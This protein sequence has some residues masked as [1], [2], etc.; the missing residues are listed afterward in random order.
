MTATAGDSMSLCV[1]ANAT[2]QGS[3]ATSAGSTMHAGATGTGRGGAGSFTALSL[4]GS[5]PRS[6]SP[7]DLMP[8]GHGRVDARQPVWAM[9]KLQLIEASQTGAI[10]PRP[11]IGSHGSLRTDRSNQGFGFATPATTRP[12]AIRATFF[13]ERP[14]TTMATWPPR[15]GL[16]RMTIA[17]C[18]MTGSSATPNLQMN[19]LP[20]SGS[21]TCRHAADGQPNRD[22]SEPSLR[23]TESARSR[24]AGSFAERRGGQ[25]DVARPASIG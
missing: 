22:H 21:N 19:K 6:I 8:A 9:G 23:N 17:S 18:L 25:V 20:R 1:A 16:G 13:S 7:L 12:V 15:V 3:P 24:S 10:G 4:S 11:R 14:R 2:D 5:G